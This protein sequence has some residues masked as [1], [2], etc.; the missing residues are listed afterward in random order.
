MALLKR[1]TGQ[2]CALAAKHNNI[3]D[4]EK[5]IRA[6]TMREVIV[7]LPKDHI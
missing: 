5:S 4:Y 7:A 2:Q 6:R 3:L 1:T